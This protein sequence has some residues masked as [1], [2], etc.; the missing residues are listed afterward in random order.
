MAG[1][2]SFRELIRLAEAR[3]AHWEQWIIGDFVQS[4]TRR[5]D[6]LH[7]SR[8]ALAQRLGVSASHITQV[9]RG[10]RNLTVQ[11]MAK[12]AR[13]ADSIVRVHLAPKGSSTRWLDMVD[14]TVVDANVSQSQE[15]HVQFGGNGPILLHKGPAAT[16]GAAAKTGATDMIAVGRG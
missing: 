9:L 8:T 10:D 6:D 2:K 5:M 12:L 1:N 3:E 15:V 16:P 7:I 13:A 11:S 4:L 14:G